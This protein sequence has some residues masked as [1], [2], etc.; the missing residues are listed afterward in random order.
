MSLINQYW[1]DYI[2]PIFMVQSLLKTKQI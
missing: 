1:Q 2:N